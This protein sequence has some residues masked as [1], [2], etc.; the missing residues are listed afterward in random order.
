MKIVLWS[1]I[2]LIGLNLQ[3]SVL[4]ADDLIGK[5]DQIGKIGME[6]NPQLSGLYRAMES[7][8]VRTPASGALPDPI[9]SFNIMNLPIDHFVFNQ[10][11]MSGKQIAFMQKFPLFGKLGLKEEIAQLSAKTRKFYW[12]EAR[13]RLAAQVRKIYLDLFYLEQTLKTIS[14]N[15]ELLRQFINVSQTRYATGKGSQQDVLKAQVALSK[16]IRMEIITQ[17]KK[18]SQWQR[19]LDLVD[20]EINAE[21]EVPDSISFKP[22]KIKKEWIKSVAFTQRPL[23]KLYETNLETLKKKA[24]LSKKMLLPDLTASIA[25]TQRDVLKTGVGGTDYLSAGISLNIPLYFKSK[26]KPE[27]QASQIA[28]DKGMDDIRNTRNLIRFQVEDLLIKLEKNVSLIRLYE[29]GI[30]PQAQQSLSAAFTG[31]QT[32][33]IDFLTLLNNQKTLL[34]LKLEYIRFLTDYY[35]SLSNLAYM[36]GLESLEQLIK[37]SQ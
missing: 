35:Q 18:E 19:L 14:E 33:K 8:S 37:K 23:L 10:E 22:E 24:L 13:N 11:P 17:Q 4:G 9:I 16:L 32:D 28:V 29:T 2:F 20:Y 26:Q 31:Y 3:Q 27:I 6:H 5:L 34:D 36:V 25:Y 15:Q 21:Y 7:D 1:I 12:Q 30:L